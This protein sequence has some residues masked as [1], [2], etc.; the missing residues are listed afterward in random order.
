MSLF[1][2][3]SLNWKGGWG[4]SNCPLLPARYTDRKMAMKVTWTCTVVN[5]DLASTSES[6]CAN[7]ST[8]QS[9]TRVP[10]AKWSRSLSCFM[11][12][13]DEDTREVPS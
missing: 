4:E 9:A 2:V 10:E 8:G 1:A 5:S 3:T 12:V 11:G 6:G 13:V 7:R